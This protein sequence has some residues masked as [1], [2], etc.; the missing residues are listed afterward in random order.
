MYFEK[1]LQYIRGRYP[2]L[3]KEIEGQGGASEVRVE[4]CRSKNGLPVAR[5]VKENRSIYLNSIY[6]PELEAKR[7]AARFADDPHSVLVLCGGGF[8]YHLKEIL[9]TDKFK[10]VVCYEP[11]PEILKAC[12]QEIDL[13]SVIG[14]KDVL[15]VAGVNQE[16]NIYNIG[17]YLLYRIMNIKIETLQVYEEFFSAEIAE[18]ERRNWDEIRVTRVNMATMNKW[19]DHW[20]INAIKNLK[21]TIHAPGVRHFFNKFNGIPA[22]VVSAGPSLEKNI[23][24]LPAI[25]EKA[26]IICAGSSIRAMLKN[27]VRPHMLLAFDGSEINVKVY[28]D[29]ELNDIYLAYNFR[30]YH[31]VVDHYAGKKI[32]LKLNTEQ[33]SD[34][35]T[36]K[37]GGYEYGAIGSGFSCSHSSLD[38]AFQLGCN[39]IVLIGQDLC[40]NFNKRYADG[41]EE[42][43]QQFLNGDKLPPN[44]L[45]AKNIYGE[46]V[47]TDMEF[48]SFRMYFEKTIRGFYH[49]KVEIINATEGGLAI[50]GTSNRKLAEVIGQYCQKDWQIT[51]KLDK[52]YQQ[53]SKELAKYGDKVLRI[54]KE[55][56]ILM[57][58]GINKI[59]ELISNVERLRKI[60]FTEEFCLEKRE[61]VLLQIT[62]EFNSALNY[63][64]YEI[65]L[66]DLRNS[67]IAAYHIAIAELGEITDSKTYDRKLQFWLNVMYDTKRTFENI[68]DCNREL[69][70]LQTNETPAKSMERRS[71]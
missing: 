13:E 58:R 1:N 29:L 25:K 33:F 49:D 68:R 59:T 54:P 10:K 2:H 47:V 61:A 60:N 48:Q 31:E 53:G 19:M 71:S 66:I 45:W 12:L 32:H 21:H 39:P 55:I 3:I 5:L 43:A 65:L 6:D 27:N 51:R 16:Q 41:Q 67:R 24:L 22:I 56:D 23:H 26:L 57:E 7:W 70:E 4:I 46:E 34:M 63:K 50:E 37:S 30:L 15:L 62:N 64:E 17:R 20:L 36:Y 40:Y 11:C 38:L 28:N 52:L 18:F 14:N 8:L 9:N 69:V 44:G 42:S 35:I